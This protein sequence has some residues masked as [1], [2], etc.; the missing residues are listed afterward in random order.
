MAYLSYPE[1]TVWRC[2]ADGSDRRQLTFPPMIA[3]FPRIS[4]DGSKVAFTSGGRA[5][6]VH[7][8]GGPPE[9]VRDDHAVAPDWSPDGNLLA[10]TS[11][12]PAAES[13][14]K[15]RWHARIV[16]IRT[17]NA[18]VVPDSQGTMGSWFATQDSLVAASEDQSKFL[19]FDFKTR[20][21]TDLIAVPDKLVS[22]MISPDR[23]YLVYATGGNDPRISRMSLTDHR[24]EDIASLKN[25]RAVND[26]NEGIQVTVGPDNLPL[27]T[28]DIGTQEVYAISV[29]WP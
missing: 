26:P 17:R 8:G 27:V 16:D 28:Q 5:Y 12:V 1:H 18:S 9:K 4:P 13:N 11:I 24:V 29:K 2:R 22:W 19:L 14:G 20:K 25:L 10:V 6:L 23:K 7:G 3:T 15:G 21:W